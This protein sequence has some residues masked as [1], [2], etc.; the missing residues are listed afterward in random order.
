MRGSSSS[1]AEMLRS[2][3]LNAA[4]VRLNRWSTAWTSLR[5]TARK[6]D[7]RRELVDW[8]YRMRRSGLTSLI[9]STPCN[10]ALN[11]GDAQRSC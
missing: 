11:N 3:V 6:G 2:A 5:R 10:L 7:G 8:R 1:P 9:C 4:D